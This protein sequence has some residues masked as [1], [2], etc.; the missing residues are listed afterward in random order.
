MSGYWRQIALLALIMVVMIQSPTCSWQEPQDSAVKDVSYLDNGI[1]RLGVSLDL[2]G[3]ITYLA[4]AK[5]KINII[6]NHDWGRQ[7]QM[8]FYSGPNPFAPNGKQPSKTWAGLGWNPI[9]TGDC[10]G[11][12]S[13]VVEHS[14]DGKL[15][16]VKCIPMQWPLNNEPGECSFES[17]IRLEGNVALVRSR[18]NNHRSDTTQYF[19][20]DQE[21]PAVYTNGPWYRLMS[22]TGDKPFTGDELSS[23]TKTWTN[24]EEVQGSPWEH[25]QATENW[26]ALVNDDNWG[27]GVFKSD[28]YSFTGGFF[29]IPGKGGS[30][31][32]P[33][34]YISPIHQ[35]I[36]DHNIQYE[37]EYNLIVGTL[38]QIR[39][40]VYEHSVRK[41]LPDYRFEKDRQ[42]WI[43]RNAVD[44]GWPIRSELNI[45]LEGNDPQLIGPV[46][47]WQAKDVPR[48]YIHAACKTSHTQ[49]EIFWKTHAG[50]SFSS[51]R[52]LGFTLQ[53]DGNYHLYEIDLAS[54]AAY[55]G[56]ITGLRFDPIP[57]G[58][59]GDY[60]KIKSISWEK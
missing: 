43:Y 17:W 16:Y 11:N 53:P 6:N 44:T 32:A 49:A 39:G 50:P 5:D 21:L 2:G 29:G 33:T 31:D 58:Q 56:A 28:V 10:A 1:I 46:G 26:A 54:C 51:D 9:Q 8:S 36:L 40:Y 55:C 27:I 38:E 13:R 59:K 20:R 45:L 47:F 35:E 22:Y 7:I 12:R 52:S 34:G 48:L 24:L 3:S 23:F 60:I 18:I 4:D 19:G 57:S 37:Y 15:L 41:A 30:K 42:H 25:W 14:N